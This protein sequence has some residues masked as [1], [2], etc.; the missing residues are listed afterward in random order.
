M[1]VSQIE[2]RL[3]AALYARSKMV[4]RHRRY[5]AGYAYDEIDGVTLNMGEIFRAHI[6]LR[7]AELVT[8]DTVQ[9]TRNGLNEQIPVI[10]LTPAGIKFCEEHIFS[11]GFGSDKKKQDPVPESYESTPDAVTA[12]K[13]DELKDLSK[14]AILLGKPVEEFSNDKFTE[15][16]KEQFL[17]KIIL[18]DAKIEEL[19]LSNSDKAQAKSLSS[20]LLIIMSAPNPPPHLVVTILKAIGETLKVS[21]SVGAMLIALLAYLATRSCTPI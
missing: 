9:S 6:A 17:Q 21:S 1:K 18:L 4:P 12:P 15:S 7:Q 10:K 20:G 8:Y 11:H 2:R 5:K 19:R 14:A 16:E 3:L 13:P